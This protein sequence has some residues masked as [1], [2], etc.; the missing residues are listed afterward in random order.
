MKNL[1]ILF[2]F[3]LTIFSHV[4]HAQDIE[5]RWGLPVKKSRIA[6]PTDVLGKDETGFYI[7]KADG[8][9]SLEKFDKNMNFLWTKKIYIYLTKKD[10]TVFENIILINNKIIVFTSFYDSKADT[11]KLFATHISKDGVIDSKLYEVNSFEKLESKRSVVYDVTISEK[12]NSILIFSNFREKDKEK[13]QFHY[14]V[15][16]E[17]FIQKSQAFIELPYTGAN[18]TIIDYIIDNAGNIH[19]IYSVN[20]K[21]EEVGNK[22]NDDKIDFN[23][24]IMSYYPA[25]K[26]YKEYDMRV[27]DY[28]ITGI[29]IIIDEESRYMYVPG[30]YSD[31]NVNALKGTLISKIDLLNKKVIYA[32]QKDFDPAFLAVVY[33]KPLDDD[34]DKKKAEEPKEKKKAKGKEQLYDYDIIDLFVNE[35]EEV[36]LVSEQ[37]YVQV[38]T[39]T[40]TTSTGMTSTRTTYYYHYNNVMVTK[41]GSSGER[42]WCSN[43]PKYQV[44]TN[45]GGFFSSIGVFAHNDVVYIIYNDNP[46]NGTVI[47]SK[48]YRTKSPQKSQLAMVSIN[49]TGELKKR[50]LMPAPDSGKGIGTRPKFSTQI[51]D[52]EVILIGYLSSYYKLGKIELK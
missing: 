13:E 28:V 16:D 8:D 2:V 19:L 7:I 47:A 50:V 30:F 18:T 40:T 32:K 12:T 1:A 21:R 43:I 26:E 44:T 42:E 25:T 46:L 20:L 36:I 38:V 37:Y 48:Q 35:N 15:I 3:V 45:D 39:Y 24:Y 6:S 31:K 9:I 52:N 10:K 17:N 29:S 5:L 41:F 11:K 34:D 23:Y 4:L 22:S 51:S 14:K 27:G 33:A 49:S